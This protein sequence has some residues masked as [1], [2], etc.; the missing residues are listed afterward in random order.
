MS[1][2]AQA[3]WCMTPLKGSPS[4]LQPFKI[5]VSGPHDKDVQVEERGH[6]LRQE[7]QQ[8]HLSRLFN[9]WASYAAAMQADLEP[10]S[11]FRS[12]RS[13]QARSPTLF[14]E[15][16]QSCQVKPTYS[17]QAHACLLHNASGTRAAH[18]HHPSCHRVVAWPGPLMVPSASQQP[19][20]AAVCKHHS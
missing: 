12:P 14:P 15:S 19:K 4:S 20:P 8:R 3:K 6:A 7:L 1:T 9:G 17:L 11:P 2:L 16:L 13:G 10:D 18:H 5:P